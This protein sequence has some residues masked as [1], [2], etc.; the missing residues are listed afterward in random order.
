MSLDVT[1]LT[2]T[3]KEKIGTGVFV[4]KDGA[5]VELTLDEVREKWPDADVSLDKYETQEVYTANIT[6]N[7]NK[8]AMAAGLYDALWRPDEQNWKIASDIIPALEAG[9]TK[10]AEDPETFKKYQ[11]ENNWGTYDGFVTFVGNYLIACK[12]NPEARIEVSR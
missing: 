4:R 8:M 3:P 6:H 7:L 9:L 2:D 10:L 12:E 11:P 1:L 5:N